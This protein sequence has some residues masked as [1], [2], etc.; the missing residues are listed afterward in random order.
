MYYSASNQQE[1]SAHKLRYIAS[2]LGIGLIFYAAVSEI[3]VLGLKFGL[4]VCKNVWYSTH[5]DMV[6]SIYQ[7]FSSQTGTWFLNLLIGLI[8]GSLTILLLKKTLHIKLKS[9]FK[10]PHDGAAYTMEGC[11]WFLGSNYIFSYITA[12]IILIITNLLGHKPYAPNFVVSTQNHWGILFNIVYAVIVAPILEEIIF[13]GFVL[14]SLQK[15]GN[16][17]AILISSF[18]FGIW[19]GNLEQSLP[20]ILSSIIFGYI[21][22]KSNSIIPSMIAHIVNNLF[23]VTMNMLSQHMSQSVYHEL[24]L[25]IIV[26][27]IIT[28]IIL[29]WM[30]GVANLK[31]HDYNQ[32]GLATSKRVITFF[33]SPAMVLFLIYI[34]YQFYQGIVG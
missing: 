4:K 22:I 34:I 24:Y 32:S 33:T 9:F 26:V 28:S 13:R 5:P 3:I 31:I 20:I 10:K 14:R 18:L 27:V 15:F 16:I 8:A 17:F 1:V 23:G 6:R 25:C 12:Y 11:F 7:F 19:H 21:A 29:I 30:R 2:M